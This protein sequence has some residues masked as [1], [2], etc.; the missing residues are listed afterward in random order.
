MSTNNAAHVPA[1]Q[2][3]EGQP[4]SDS[5]GWARRTEFEKYTT[6]GGESYWIEAD[7]PEDEF[8][9]NLGLLA[10]YGHFAITVGYDTVFSAATFGIGYAF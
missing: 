3:K 6:P 7:N 2:D 9:F 1:R 10:Y 5:L 8:N 4:R